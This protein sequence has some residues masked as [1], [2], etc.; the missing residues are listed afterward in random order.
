[1]AQVR[2]VG[3]GL[4]FREALAPV[5]RRVEDAGQ[6]ARLLVLGAPRDDRRADLHD[7]VGVEDPGAAV[8]GHHLRVD[9]LLGGR[10]G[11]A[12]PLLGPEDG[13]PPA[14]VELVLPGLALVH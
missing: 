9:D 5:L 12:A 7:A 8:L 3:A 10:R 4:W 2:K 6:P 1:G 11:P 13:G 14:L